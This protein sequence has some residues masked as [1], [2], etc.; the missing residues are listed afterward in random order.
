[1]VMANGYNERRNNNW[2]VEL[3]KK[4]KEKLVV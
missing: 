4:E 1:M 2:I 3:K